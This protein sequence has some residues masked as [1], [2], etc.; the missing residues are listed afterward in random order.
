MTVWLRPPT[1]SGVQVR[2]TLVG[3]TPKVALVMVKE[4]PAV[5]VRA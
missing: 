1:N 2:T 4:V 3:A 5:L